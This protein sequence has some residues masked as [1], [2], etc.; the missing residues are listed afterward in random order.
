MRF[1]P[2]S[3]EPFGGL[4][5]CIAA[6]RL[7]I[8]VTAGPVLWADAPSWWAER[9][10]LTP[11]VTV[12]DYAAVNQGQVKHIAKQAYEEM[13]NK[14]QLIGGAGSTLDGIWASPTTSSDDYQ[15]I[16]LGQLK[17]VAEPFYARLQGINYTGQPLAAGLTR[18]WSGTADNYSIANIG[19]VKNVFSF[20]LSLLIPDSD[21][22]GL[23]DQWEL[24][25]F[26]NLSYSG[27]EDTDGDG[28]PNRIEFFLG[29]DPTLADANALLAKIGNLRLQL[30]AGSVAPGTNNKVSV[31]A[32]QS[33]NTNNAYQNSTSSQ[34]LLVASELNGR[35]VIRFDGSDD[36]LN[37]PNVMSLAAAG[38]IIV[39]LKV[40]DAFGSRINALWNFG[41]RNGSSYYSGGRRMDDFG[42]VGNFS[43]NEFYSSP[44]ASAVAQFHYYNI[45][46]DGDGLWVDRLNGLERQRRTGQTPSFRSSPLIGSRGGYGEYLQGDIAEILVFDKALSEKERE[47]AY[48]YL[49]SKYALPAIAVPASP[50]NVVA[51]AFSSD[52]V[53]LAWTTQESGLQTQATVERSTAGGRFMSVADLAN[54]M[55]YTDTGLV[56]GETYSYRVKLRS[57]GGSSA[58][59]ST[60]NVVMPTDTVVIPSAGLRLWL[61]ADQGTQGAGVLSTWY[62]QSSNKNH[63]VQGDE[64]AKPLIVANQINGRPVVRFD[65]SN[66]YL[67]LPNMLSGAAAG[68]IIA[69]L[70]VPDAFGSRINALWNFGNRNG[71]SYYSQNSRMDDFGS[72]GNFS[73]NEFYS[74]PP[75]SVVEQ[76]H[77]YNISIDGSG[78]WVDRLNGLERQR[79]TGQSVSFRPSPLIG[80]RGGYSEYLQGDIAEILVYDRALTEPEREATNR[81]LTAKYAPS[82]IPVPAA[83]TGLRAVAMA[84]NQVNLAWTIAESS[85]RTTATIE[86]KSGGGAFEVVAVKENA[87]EFTDT[88]PSPGTTYTY[89]VKLASFAGSSAYSSEVSATTLLGTR[90]FPTAGLRLRLQAG[91]GGQGVGALSTWFDQSNFANHATQGEELSKPSVVANQLNGLPVV[92]FD[93]ADDY[94][95]LPNVMTSPSAGEIIA[96]LKVPDA[97]GSRINALWHFGNRNGSSYYSSAR[98][99]DDFGSAGHF[100]SSG[101]EYYSSPSASAVAQFHTYNI[102]ITAGGLWVD[103]LNGLERVRRTGQAPSFRTNPLIGKRHNYGEYLKG[104]IAE[105]LVYDRV[106]TDS[107][108]ET[109]YYTLAQR[110]QVLPLNNYVAYSDLNGDGIP[111]AMGLRAG[112]A[113]SNLDSDGDGVRNDIELAQGTD[114]LLTDTDGDG[115]NDGSDFYPLDPTRNQPLSPISGDVTAPGITLLEP[116]DATLIP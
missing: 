82:A 21:G 42:S 49:N 3:V 115:V 80:S 97:F 35:P 38:E 11:G 95:S 20:D 113:I 61:K 50:T 68:E 112:I 54:A 70:K 8:G 43:G 47:A 106:L 1:N 29:L 85:V 13:K 93:G 23:L 100:S 99:M 53:T 15:V 27:D 69:V 14:L 105:I 57:Y 74:S 56:A 75:A 116:T 96:V 12:D 77:Y 48:V 36:Y 55:G 51:K 71:S 91:T 89:R 59:S 60:V 108:R 81:Y 94:L 6:V 76:F 84:S 45:S 33:G 16:N 9:G 114:P 66:D 83:P 37:L 25:Y 63:A 24:L 7:L 26:P 101:S 86:R 92:R 30:T 22:D 104:D 111:D 18:P 5:S 34:P 19:Q 41:N 79:R 31:W 40:P 10:V 67:S 98:R 109:V 62:D 110:Y 107:E 44:S 90:D 2:S 17:N 73:G 39:V 102:S 28:I 64:S 65:G 4:I 58:Y 103:R 88:P 32:D 78:L 52:A 87:F 46:M 72:S